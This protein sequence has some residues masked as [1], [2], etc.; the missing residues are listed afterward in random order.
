MSLLKRLSA[1]IVSRVDQMVSQIENHDAVVEAAIRE[2]RQ[3]AAKARVRLSRVRGDGEK[4]QKRIAELRASQTQWTERARSVA[5]DDR[6]RA[7]ECM[8]CRNECL[9]QIG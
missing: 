2:S 5:A 9:A 4:L 8:R 1:T 3:A 6:D 7:L